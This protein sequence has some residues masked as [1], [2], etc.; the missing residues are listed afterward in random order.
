[1]RR[2]GLNPATGGDPEWDRL[3][4]SSGRKLPGTRKSA[5][6]GIVLRFERPPG[7]DA[8]Q[9]AAA[10]SLG[11]PSGKV[12]Q[13]AGL[14]FNSGQAIL[15]EFECE[16][17]VAGAVCF[18]K[19][20]LLRNGTPNVLKHGGPALAFAPASQEIQASREGYG[21]CEP[22]RLARLC[23]RGSREF[24]CSSIVEVHGRRYQLRKVGP[25]ACIFRQPV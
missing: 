3:T 22:S 21:R 9:L 6:G 11:R 10:A 14:F 23:Q 16:I 20:S 1:L 12:P 8:S 5:I 7:W 15:G 17:V 18:G 24:L 25:F 4:D 13:D 19:L 2:V